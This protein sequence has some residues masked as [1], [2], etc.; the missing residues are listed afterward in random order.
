[1]SNL[2]TANKGG[3]RRKPSPG[4]KPD[5]VAAAIVEAAD[6][7]DPVPALKHQLTIAARMMAKAERDRSYVA[8]ASLLRQVRDVTR[9]LQAAVAA[10]ARKATPKKTTEQQI[11]SIVDSLASMPDMLRERII[12]EL[13]RRRG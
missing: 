4:I 13:T 6:S 7:V 5:V 12:A 9:D 8:A 2:V 3:G 11:A 1:M 10:A